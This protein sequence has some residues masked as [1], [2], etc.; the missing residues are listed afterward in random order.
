MLAPAF[1]APPALVEQDAAAR[2][3]LTRKSLRL[4]TGSI[5]REA[6]FCP[7]F[8]GSPG[9]PSSASLVHGSP[10]RRQGSGPGAGSPSGACVAASLCSPLWPACSRSLCPPRSR[11]ETRVKYSQ[12]RP[13]CPSPVLHTLLTGSDQLAPS[14][15]PPVRRVLRSRSNSC[16]H[17]CNRFRYFAGF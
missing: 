11:G 17:S 1:S 9:P 12:G 10:W 13:F 6:L 5:A 3:G 4:P 15:H 16:F 14:I 7:D 8:S 2:G